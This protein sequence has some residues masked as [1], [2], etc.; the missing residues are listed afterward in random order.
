MSE[1]NERSGRSGLQI[2]EEIIPSNS[3]IKDFRDRYNELDHKGTLSDII[4]EAK[5]LSP[6][7]LMLDR[8]GGEGVTGLLS[9]EDECLIIGAEK[10][11]KL[12]IGIVHG[13]FRTE[14]GAEGIAALVRESGA[15]K[16]KMWMVGV[17]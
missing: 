16:P 2:L 1:K 3:S 15:A 8:I 5:K 11:G 14:S 7:P 6:K 9:D 12:T 17:S 10:E 13:Y 4:L